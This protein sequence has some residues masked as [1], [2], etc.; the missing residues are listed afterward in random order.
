M[1]QRNP[2]PDRRLCLEIGKRLFLPT[3]SVQQWFRNTRAAVKLK[4]KEQQ[5]SL[6]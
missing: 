1:F 6:S 3:E 2:K 5:A 4:M